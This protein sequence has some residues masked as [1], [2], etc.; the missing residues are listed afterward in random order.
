MKKIFLFSIVLLSTN[1]VFSQAGTKWSVG[2]NTLNTGDWLGSTNFEPII[3]KT[4]NQERFRIDANGRI[5]FSNLTATGNGLLILSGTGIADRLNFTGNNSDVLLGTGS[6][7]PLNSA[8]GWNYFGGN[9]IT[10]NKVGIGVSVPVQALEVNGN[11][12][13]NGTVAAQE[14]VVGD[15]TSNGKNLRI[16]TNICL[17]GYDPSTGMRN[18]ICVFTQPLFLNSKHGYNFNTIINHD[19]TGNVGIG[20]D[21]PLQKLHVNGNFRVDGE[22]FYPGNSHF[23]RISGMPGDTVIRFGDSTILLNHSTNTIY[24]QFPY[25]A[26]YNKGIGVG[27]YASVGKGLFTTALGHQSRAMGDYS[28]TMGY[29]VR[30]NANNSMVIGSG[31]TGNYLEN[32]IANSLMIGFNSNIPTLFVSGSAG[33]NTTGRIG[34]GT[35]TPSEKFE[36][37]HSDPNGGMVL[38]KVG[39]MTGSKSEIKF[40]KN[41]SELFAIG[42]D[43]DNNDSQTFFIWNH[44]AGSAPLLINQEGKVGIGGTIPPVN[45]TIY[46][47]YVDGGIATRDI[48]VTNSTTWPDNVFEEDYSLMSVEDMNKYIKAHHHLPGVPSAAEVEKN[49][50]FELGEMEVILLKKIEEQALYIIDMK[51]EMMEMKEEINELKSGKK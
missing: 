2:G 35:S 17:D 21:N 48:K 50:G 30:A 1:I 15:V 20:T 51:E 49:Q 46:K 38:N 39:T 26:G 32:N 27:S 40:N 34:I 25:P 29:F 28:H 5:V 4:D 8:A 42:C 6:F 7:G 41:G 45:G 11:S 47:L 3:F 23:Y 37:A 19:N 12:I 36:V 33:L 10:N 9:T 24:V 18:E 44:I 13:F 22:S 16:N 31:M 14:F 43:F